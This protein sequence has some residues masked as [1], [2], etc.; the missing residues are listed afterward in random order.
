[1]QPIPNL[2]AQLPLLYWLEVQ[3]AG[4]LQRRLHLD[5]WAGQ[6]G[7]SVLT[8]LEMRISST[9][10]RRQSLGRKWMH[11]NKFCTV[12]LMKRNASTCESGNDSALGDFAVSFVKGHLR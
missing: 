4:Q 1:M 7:V 9:C 3:A 10:F 11:V 6:A 12:C 2:T 5:I 8:R